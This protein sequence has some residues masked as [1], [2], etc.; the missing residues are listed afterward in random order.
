MYIPLTSTL[1]NGRLC[2]IPVELFDP[3]QIII[4]F[5]HNKLF[6][7]MGLLLRQN[8]FS[9]FLTHFCPPLRLRN[10]LLL[11]IPTFAVRETDVSRTANVGTVGMNG[12]T[13]FQQ[14]DYNE[15]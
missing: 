1:F 2:R 5:D 9:L 12:L 15:T 10:Q 3:P 13:N 11:T 14:S 8:S 6:Y 7:D 4:V